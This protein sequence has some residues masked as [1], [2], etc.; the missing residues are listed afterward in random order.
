MFKESWDGSQVANHHKED[1]NK[2]VQTATLLERQ[3]AILGANQ[4]LYKVEK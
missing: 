4:I 3:F 1:Q 2:G